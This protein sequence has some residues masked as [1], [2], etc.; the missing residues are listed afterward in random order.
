MGQQLNKHQNSFV[1]SRKAASKKGSVQ[2][3]RLDLLE[4]PN[5]ISHGTSKDRFS[6]IPRMYKSK[7]DDSST[8]TLI[9]CGFDNA[10]YYECK[11]VNQ[12]GSDKTRASLTVNKLTS[13]EK[14]EYEK[15]KASGLLDAVADEE[16]K[17]IEKK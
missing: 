6:K 3:L 11:A 16:E 2:D 4:T 7:S 13:E 17:V 14:A 12:L 9:D 15:A 1:K 8:L 5:L 10:G